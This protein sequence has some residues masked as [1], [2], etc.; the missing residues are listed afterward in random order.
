MVLKQ[1]YA[2]HYWLSLVVRGKS[3]KILFKIKNYIIVEV[4]KDDAR[5]P[6]ASPE[7]ELFL[8]ASCR[9]CHRALAGLFPWA[10]KMQG[11]RQRRAAGP[12]C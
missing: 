7:C 1:W 6:E 12:K 4:C 9:G 2:Y 8:I 3:P 11:G 5:V 10:L